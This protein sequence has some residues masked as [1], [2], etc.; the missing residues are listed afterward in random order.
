MAR[1]RPHLL[2]PGCG[3]SRDP[4]R[5]DPGIVHHL[6]KVLR[7]ESAA[8]S[9]TDGEGLFGIGTYRNGLIKRSE[10]AMISRP[11]HLTVAVAPPRT[12]SRL[13]FVVEKMAELGVRRLFWL[14]TARTEGR[15]PRAEKA[16]RWA[17]AALEQSQGAWLMEIGSKPVPIEMVSEIGTP[18]FAE[19]GG[20]DPSRVILPDDHVLCIGPEGGF[21]PEEVPAAAMSLSLGPTVLRVET[22]A[23]VA[24]TLLRN[25]VE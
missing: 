13:R 3:D 7:V 5:V 18:V 21:S 2:V 10:E 23:V 24:V 4:M 20:S 8:V 15:P 12:N 22:A 9:Y 17:I 6:E 1:H 25:R 19:A 11:T 16:G 14:R